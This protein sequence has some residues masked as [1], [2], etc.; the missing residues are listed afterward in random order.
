M[1]NS[2]INLILAD[3]DD[4]D[5]DFFKEALDE[6]PLAT[7]LLTVH[8]GQE[9][10]QYLTQ[11]ENT[12]P[13]V[14]FL[15]LNMPRKSGFD[16]LLEIKQNEKLKQLPVII[17]STSLDAETTN[18]LQQQGANYCLRKPVEFSQFKEVMN[19]LVAVRT[20]SSK[21]LEQLH[22][23]LP[24]LGYGRKGW[25]PGFGRTGRLFF[26]QAANAGGNTTRSSSIMRDGAGQ[27]NCDIHNGRAP[28]PPSFADA[29]VHRPSAL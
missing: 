12:L 21:G 23:A 6:L 8:D 28:T 19:G 29:L 25:P 20:R 14:L 15:D 9:L 27:T 22:Q 10:M 24:D 4:D 11:E 1:D 13:H 26:P 17:F 2:P 3:D 7:N 18:R 16:C 5:C